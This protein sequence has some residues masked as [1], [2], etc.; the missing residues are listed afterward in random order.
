MTSTKL[1]KFQAARCQECERNVSM[2]ARMCRTPQALASVAVHQLIRASH[3]TPDHFTIPISCRSKV[4]VVG[5]EYVNKA[6]EL[7]FQMYT[8]AT[9][10][11]ST[12]SK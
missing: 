3:Q 2:M 8:S 1:R 7:R 12:A 5:S 6:L 11:C 10:G 4:R 9:A